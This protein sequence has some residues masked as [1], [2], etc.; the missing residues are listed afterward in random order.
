[1]NKVL[2]SIDDAAALVRANSVLGIGGFGAAGVPVDLLAA[3]V[4]SEINGLH[5][6]SNNCAGT[7]WRS[8]ALVESGQI[9]RASV[10]YLGGSDVL[11]ELFMAGRIEVELIPQ[12][13]LAERL[14]AGGAG[15]PAFYTPTGVGTLVE[16]GGIPIRY[17]PEGE[18]EQVSE[19]K[20]S[21][22][23][24]GKKY[25]LEHA[26]RCD[27][28][29]I[30]A[31]R[32]DHF[33]NLQFEKSARNFNPLVAMASDITIVEADEIVG[34]G[35][36]APQD[37]DL[38]GAFVD[39]VVETTTK[40]GVIER[41][42]L[43]TD[44]ATA[45]RQPDAKTWVSPQFNK[46]DFIAS[47]AA[48]HLRNGEIVNLGIGLPT[49]IPNYLLRDVRPTIH[50]ENG[51]LG[52]GAYPS[53]PEEADPDLINAGKE[54]VTLETG[55]SF[56][57]SSLSFAMIRGG[58]VD[59]SVLGAMQVSSAG[60]IASWLIPGQRVMGMGG[61]MDLVHGAKRVIAVMEHTDGHGRPK[62]VPNC[63]LPLTG[64]GV[65]DYIVTDRA[66][67]A[68]QNGHLVLT[69]LAPGEALDDLR[70]ATAAQF[71]IGTG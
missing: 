54:T 7:G 68:I 18:I 39:Y 1:M 19:P 43:K 9:R 55:A 63:T 22:D 47:R 17:G 40:V 37:V 65:V 69:E 11:V 29:L 52:V 60:D 46:R 35:N 38:P 49:L 59:T 34:T 57:D 66:E 36:I 21:R 5:T 58:R 30:H 14:R 3:L 32:A 50:S 28:G 10:S 53:S 48:R 61:A 4:R 70:S 44:R 67:F 62:I 26:I 13:S 2:T 12:G 24:G 31:H 8:T 45:S 71:E 64:K 51:I 6:Y 56:F 23:F 41:L 27:A 33:G 42:T 25:L 20:E 15:L 16:L